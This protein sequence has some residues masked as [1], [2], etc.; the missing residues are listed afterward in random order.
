LILRQG[1]AGAS[2]FKKQGDI[3]DITNVGIV[4]YGVP[5]VKM[6]SV[7]EM[8]GVGDGTQQHH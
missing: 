6:K 7:L 5:I 4:L 1:A 2:V 3:A 8:I